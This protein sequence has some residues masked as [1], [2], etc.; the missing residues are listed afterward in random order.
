MYRILR[1]VTKDV[2]GFAHTARSQS[3]AHALG[4]EMNN[5]PHPGGVASSSTITPS[6]IRQIEAKA[7]RK[8]ANPS[9]SERLKV[10]GNN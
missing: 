5:R 4:I 6:G 3:A 9:R 10:P 1:E 7:L 2:L 8:L